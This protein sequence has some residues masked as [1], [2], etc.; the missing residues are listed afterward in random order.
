MGRSRLL[1][2]VVAAVALL[3]GPIGSAAAHD[4]LVGS[5]PA[6]DAAVGIAPAGV[7]LEFSE[8]PQPLG[9]EVVVTGPD[10]AP[11]SDGAPELDGTAVTQP[12]VEDL[13]AGTYTVDWRV[14]SADGHP[15]SGTF[16]F[17]V[18][19]GA[20]AATGTAEEGGLM[21]PSTGSPSF[22]VVWLVIGVIPVAAGVLVVWQLRRSS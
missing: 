8:A 15:L 22:P 6:Q 4:V 12:L 10:G 13:P 14:T 19:D 11:V 5:K 18:T 7:S 3:L 16:T 2:P 21:T 17:D 9:T 1:V 20:P